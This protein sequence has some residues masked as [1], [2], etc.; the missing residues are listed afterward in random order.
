MHSGYH[1][2]YFFTEATV[3]NKHTLVIP[4]KMTSLVKKKNHSCGA[5]SLVLVHHR[6]KPETSLESLTGDRKENFLI[7][8][9]EITQINFKNRSFNCYCYNSIIIIIKKTQ[10][11]I[12]FPTDKGRFPR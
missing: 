12:I 11:H 5:F 6:R 2:Y 1:I 8:R 10:H 9:K 7:N 4:Q 3:V